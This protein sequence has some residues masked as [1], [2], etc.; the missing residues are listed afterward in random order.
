[1]KDCQRSDRDRKQEIDTPMRRGVVH[2]NPGPA[3]TPIDRANANAVYQH[4]QNDHDG[5]K[6]YFKNWVGSR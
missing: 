3:E 2:E 4:D 5:P 6:R 1:M